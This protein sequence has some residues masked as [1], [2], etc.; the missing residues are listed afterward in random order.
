MFNNSSLSPD[1][2]VKTHGISLT[3]LGKSSMLSPWFHLPALDQLPVAKV[4]SGLGLWNGPLLGLGLPSQPPALCFFPSPQAL[5][6]FPLAMQVMKR[7]EYVGKET[8]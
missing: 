1:Y 5:S 4:L 2:E 3:P 6:S 8:D 7:I